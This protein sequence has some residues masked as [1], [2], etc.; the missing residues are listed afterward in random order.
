P[1][2]IRASRPGYI[3][4]IPVA[5]SSRDF[6]YAP[7]LVVFAQEQGWYGGTGP[8]DFNKVYGG[9]KG[10]WAGGRWIQDEM[11]AR[12]HRPE[13]TAPADILWAVRTEKLPGDTAGYGQVVP[14]VHP[15]HA[16][17]RHLWH[18]Q[19]GAIAAPFVPVFMGVRDV[20]EEYRQ[21]R[22]LTAG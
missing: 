17:L 21:H 11:R 15:R 16:A 1:D 14:L 4:E 18:T 8:F 12:W 13:K 2:S 3:G 19:I 10:R 9:G 6:L 7:N 22:Y 5:A 20:P